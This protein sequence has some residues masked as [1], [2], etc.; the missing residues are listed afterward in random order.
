MLVRSI[1][2]APLLLLAA[3]AQ[4]WGYQ[5]LTGGP[6]DAAS[7]RSPR[8]A[9]V[10]IDEDGGD[11]TDAAGG[12]VIDATPDAAD[13]MLSTATDGGDRDAGDAC[14]SDPAWCD[15]RCGPSKDNC[16]R[17]VSC[18]SC[19]AEAGCAM[20]ACDS[21]AQCCTGYCGGSGTCVST[22]TLATGSCGVLTSSSTCC[23]GLT[24]KTGFPP[25]IHTCQ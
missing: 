1:S 3:C 12:V 13:A 23:Y 15:V 11:A 8:D 16:G 6:D 24:C 4:V 18:P 2:L 20:G 5:D 17:V 21:G 25:I 22:C 9:T 10:V 14:V 7:M 19:P